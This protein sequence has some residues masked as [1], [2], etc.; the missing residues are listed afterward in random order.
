MNRSSLLAAILALFA[1]AARAEEPAP[2]FRS[3]LMAGAGTSF[4][5][6][7]L[8]YELGTDHL[9]FFAAT[10]PLLVLQHRRPTPGDNPHDHFDFALGLRY[11]SRPTND[12]LCVS[13]QSTFS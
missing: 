8:R 13:L 6:Y 7:G 5:V 3:A 1:A 10:G 12:R 11:F 2:T 4:D 9:A